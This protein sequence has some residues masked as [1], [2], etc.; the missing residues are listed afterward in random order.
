MK[1]VKISRKA[2]FFFFLQASGGTA[3]TLLSVK[4]NLYSPPI[5]SEGK[6]LSYYTIPN[7]KLTF[8]A[9]SDTVKVD[10]VIVI[11]EEHEAEK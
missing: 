3:Q 1:N 7:K 9:I 10:I 6:K 4:S 5:T 2:I 11:A 8:V